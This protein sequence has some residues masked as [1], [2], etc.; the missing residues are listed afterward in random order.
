LLPHGAMGIL[1]ELSAS[2]RYM[3]G[4]LNNEPRE[5]HQY[6]FREFDLRKH[7]QVSFTSSYLHLRKPDLSF[8]KK[9]LDLLCCPAERILF[10]DDRQENTH[11]A[12]GVGMHAIHFENASQLRANWWSW[13]CSN[14]DLDEWAGRVDERFWFAGTRLPA[15]ALPDG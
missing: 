1:H 14:P 12:S 9:A 11:A 13:A 5:T 10:L 6:R 7:F 3:L 4:A 8:F 2:H 15:V